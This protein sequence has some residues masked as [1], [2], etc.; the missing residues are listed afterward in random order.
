MRKVS[1]F[2]TPEFRL[3]IVREY[4]SGNESAKD[5]GLK[6][7]VKACTIHQW[8][9]RY[10]NSENFVSLPKEPTQ[11]SFMA[12]TKQTFTDENEMLKQRLKEL[13]KRLKNAELQN[14]ALNTMIDIAEEQGIQIRK[15]SGAKQ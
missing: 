8:A 5:L 3:K 10:G 11:S 1:K 7:Q 15:K 4:L 14:L 9:H 12:G 6:Y 13:E 2:T